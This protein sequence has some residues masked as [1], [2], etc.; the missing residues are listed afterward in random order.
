MSKSI[1]GSL[2]NKEV[3]KYLSEYKEFIEEE[4]E[5]I[6]KNVGKEAMNELKM[7][8]P[9]GVKK[10]YSKGWKT[11]N[12]RRK[13]SFTVKIYNKTDGS[14]THLLEYGH[15]T[16]NGGRTE[17]IP[18]IRPVEEKYSN[19]FEQTLKDNIRRR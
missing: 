11:Q 12:S 10:R 13:N 14:L 17:A 3:M 6:G 19:K 1:D 16:K 18:H 15:A 9:R 8:S 2:L 5:K 4:V 7:T